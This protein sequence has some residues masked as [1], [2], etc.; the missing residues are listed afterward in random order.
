MWSIGYLATVNPQVPGSS[1][2]RGATVFVSDLGLSPATPAGLF[3]S[4]IA[5]PKV[6]GLV[7]EKVYEKLQN[8]LLSADPVSGMLTYSF[9]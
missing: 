2:G 7:S 3:F 1:P 4:G 9:Y 6:R 8:A 5:I